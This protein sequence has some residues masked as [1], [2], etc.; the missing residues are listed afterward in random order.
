MSSPPLPDP[1]VIAHSP[2]AD[3]AF[4]FYALSTGKVRAPVRVEHVL[5][6]IETLNREAERGT[7]HVTAISA[8]AYP[9]VRDRYRLLAT[10]GSVGDGYG[11]I[12]VAKR[13]AAPADLAGRTVAIPG[14]RTTAALALRLLLPAVRT[15]VVPFDRILDAVASGQ[16]EAGLVIHEGQLTYGDGGLSKVADL[17]E[18]W[19]AETGLPLPLGLNGVRR[20]L[21]DEAARVA[22]AAI[23]D[24]VAWAL[25]HRPEALAHALRFARGAG[26]ERAD[27]FV[28]MYVNDFTRDLG[29]RGRAGLAALY[30][31]ARSAGL[32]PDPGPL[33]FG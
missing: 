32:I 33:E 15:T 26:R 9:Y 7:Y 6:D 30:D 27:R 5:S 2:D 28:G 12:V 4:M 23:G 16:V 1:L 13:P 11:P 17:G 25:A 21:G 24:S 14:E 8:H 3:D 19:A 22:S 20:D 31:R 29:P 10:G 18:L